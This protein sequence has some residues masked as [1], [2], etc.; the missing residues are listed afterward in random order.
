M[1]DHKKRKAASILLTFLLMTSLLASCGKE[2]EEYGSIGDAEITQEEETGNQSSI[3]TK[4]DNPFGEYAYRTVDYQNAKMRFDIP[5]TWLEKVVNP[6]CIRYDVPADDKYFPGAR[7]YVKCNYSYPA[8][9]DP[10][11]NEYL[12][13]AT[14]FS[15]NMKPYIT[16]LPY[17]YGKRGNT[18]INDYDS[19][20]ELEMPEFCSDETAAC[21]TVTKNAVLMDKVTSDVTHLRGMDF[22]AGY[23]RWDIFPVMIATVVPSEWSGNAKSLISYIMSSV[24]GTKQKLQSAATYDFS[25]ASLS[26]PM[27]FKAREGQDNVFGT[28]FDDIK[29]TS[30]ISIGVFSLPNVTGELPID[31][32]QSEYADRLAG[33]LLDPKVTEHYFTATSA[34]EYLGDKLADEKDAYTIYVTLTTDLYDYTGAENP[35]GLSDTSLIDVYTIERGGHYYMVATLYSMQQEDI[36]RKVTRQALQTLACK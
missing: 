5:K 33:I 11:H 35:Y 19:P 27:D 8:V 23:F 3:F 34:S 30:G 2:T 36:A 29:S 28:S 31:V 13:V 6:S 7:F 20:D 32:L 16:G 15:K 17:P 4:L 9:P 24:T 22:V 12:E 1:L 18:W 25:E 21:I 26:L 10:H 14:E